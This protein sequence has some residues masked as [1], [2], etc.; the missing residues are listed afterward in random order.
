MSKETDFKN[1]NAINTALVCICIMYG[2]PKREV[3][4]QFSKTYREALLKEITDKWETKRTVLR[5][6]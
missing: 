3:L 1:A 4:K 2:L 6:N 5:K